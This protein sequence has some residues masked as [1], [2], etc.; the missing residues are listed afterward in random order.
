[1]PDLAQFNYNSI[2]SGLGNGVFYYISNFRTVFFDYGDRFAQG[3]KADSP[4]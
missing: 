3:I 4:T 2:M 1:M